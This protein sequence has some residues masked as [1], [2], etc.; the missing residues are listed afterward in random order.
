V[1]GVD[2]AAA[3]AVFHVRDAQGHWHRGA[4]AFV[5][6]WHH[7]G[8]YRA[9]GKLVRHSGLTPV[10]SRAYAYFARWRLRRRCQD[11]SCTVA[12]GGRDSRAPSHGHTGDTAPLG[13][14]RC[15]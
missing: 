2:H 3:M 9:L 10:L 8:P 13:D 15:E 5:E 4:H 7:L 11:A 6:L 14:T 1:H 12:T